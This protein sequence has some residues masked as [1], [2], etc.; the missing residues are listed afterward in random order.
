M[1]SVRG[2]GVQSCPGLARASKVTAVPPASECPS[3]ERIL[4]S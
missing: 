2:V 1:S 3:R 4:E